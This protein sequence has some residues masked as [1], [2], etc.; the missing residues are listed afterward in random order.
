M[1]EAADAAAYLLMTILITKGEFDV[2]IHIPSQS[3]ILSCKLPS[4]ASR[5]TMALFAH[6]QKLWETHDVLYTSPRLAFARAG[7]EKVV[8][9][10]PGPL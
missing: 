8:V 1:H 7:Q 5:I 2:P 9:A 4:V 3:C 10:F 6:Y